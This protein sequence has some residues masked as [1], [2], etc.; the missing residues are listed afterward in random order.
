[1]IRLTRQTAAPLVA[2]LEP[3]EDDVDC[4]LERPSRSLYFPRRLEQLFEQETQLA[5]SSHL[6]GVGV[7]WIMMGAVVSLIVRNNVGPAPFG[8]NPTVRLA[9]VTPVLAAVVTAVW[10]GV[11]PFVRELLMMLACIIAPASLMVGV[12]LSPGDDIGTNRGAL[13]IILLFITVVVRLRFWFSAVACFVL[14]ALQVG[15]PIVLQNS[16]PGNGL[17]SLITIAATL[18]ANYVL[19][20]EYR[21]NYLHRLHSRIQGARLSAMVAQLHDLSQRDPLTSLDNRRAMDAYLDELCGRHEPFS[22]ILVDIDAFKA[23][24][25]CYGHQIGDDALRRVAAMLRASLRFTSDRIARLGGEE[26]I[27]V[28]PQTALEDAHIMAERMRT[29]VSALRIPHVKSPTG[30]V[31]TVSLGVSYS[32]GS[33]TAEAPIAEADKALYRAKSLG[34]DRVEVAKDDK[35]DVFIPS[36]RGMEF[37]KA[38]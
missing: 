14:I 3:F 22:V 27:V 11:R 8:I 13:T 15:L 10:W 7:L 17:L 34:R 1:M 37:V 35:S 26:F 38:L 4:M 2:D 21:Q 16:V 24:N 20:R 12:M 31:V 5:R 28:L 25:D 33:T 23:F 30:S 18:T 19:E 29:S 36:G 32:D 9:I 6:V